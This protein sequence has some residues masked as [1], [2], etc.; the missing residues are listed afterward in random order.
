[1]AH[2]QIHL[3]APKRSLEKFLEN[4]SYI[5]SAHEL[6]TY[7]VKTHTQILFQN[8]LIALAVL[9]KLHTQNGRISTNRNQAERRR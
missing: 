1:M 2:G 9:L 5:R 6:P 7:I 8:F 4:L 3:T